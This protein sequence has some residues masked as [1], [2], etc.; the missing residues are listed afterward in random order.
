[1][2]GTS[3]KMSAYTTFF[4]NITTAFYSAK[5]VANKYPDDFSALIEAMNNL[6][7]QI[8]ST[9][10]RFNSSTSVAQK[11]NILKAF[12]NYYTGADG[13]QKT[14]YFPATDRYYNRQQ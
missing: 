10:S 1:M 3:A 6:E 4:E 5:A 14:Q 13:W 7:K 11:L 2:W 12:C 8:E 9:I